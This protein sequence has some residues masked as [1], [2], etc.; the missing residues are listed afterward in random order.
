[1]RVIGAVLLALGAC[2][3]LE[4]TS[5]RAGTLY[6]L[7]THGLEQSGRVEPGGVR[8][9]TRFLHGDD[10][11][12]GVALLSDEREFAYAEA[13]AGGKFA[14]GT[15]LSW[16]RADELLE[17]AL[18][19]R[20]RRGMSRDD[21]LYALGRPRSVQPHKGDPNNETVCYESLDCELYVLV[22]VEGKLRSWSRHTLWSNDF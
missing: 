3:S 6:V 15:S 21:V 14:F 11:R 9:I 12:V 13:K 16:R 17:A 1:M 8:S 22:F 10:D 18:A 5:D 19:G 2:T 7:G 20:I 4:V